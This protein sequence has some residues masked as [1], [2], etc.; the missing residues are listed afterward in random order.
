MDIHALNDTTKWPSPDSYRN[1]L[2]FPH[3]VIDDFLRPDLAR[4]LAGIFPDPSNECWWRYSNPLERKL[5]CNIPGKVPARIWETLAFFNTDK[6]LSLF[7]DLTGIADL[8]ADHELHGGGMHCIESGGKLD[9]HVD[10]SVHPKLGLERRLNLILYLNTNWDPQWGGELQLW[11]A[12]M[13]RCVQK[14]LPLFNRAVIFDTGDGS[15]HGHP[16]ALR[17]PS[18]EARKSL[19]VYYLTAPRPEATARYRARFVGR[20][21]DPQDPEL[22]ELRRLRAGLTTGSGVYRVAEK[23]E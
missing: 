5:A 23:R 19:A 10:Y 6:C 22:E 11:D 15:F 14:I 7:S 16:D 4:E 21:E 13:T 1:A 17:C 2:P 20:P 18:G 12:Q 3:A 8:K 9:I